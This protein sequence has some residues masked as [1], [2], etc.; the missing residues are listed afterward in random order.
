AGK[1]LG[2]EVVNVSPKGSSMAKGESLRD[3][4][5]T[6]DAMAP[7]VIVVRH[8]SPGAAAFL[9]REVAAG[10]VNAGD[11]AHQ[12]P[13][14]ALLDALT[15]KDRF[16]SLEGRRI[17]ICGDIRHSRVARSSA[18]LLHLLGARVRLGGPPTLLPRD[19]AGWGA[20][21]ATADMDEAI[22]GC[23][24][25]M[26]LRVQLERARGAVVPPIAE[27]RQ[28]YGLDHA[29]LARLAPD[30]LVMHP[31]PANRGVEIAADLADDPA[32]SLIRDQVE[33]GVAARMAVLERLL[34]PAE[35]AA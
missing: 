4:A 24:V 17:A 32:R 27:Y 33:A 10:V 26:V 16:G 15:L 12:H 8:S 6:V 35:A 34:A 21:T 30:A 11:G 9:A 31:G 3:T 20:E 25:V 29:R 14:Q 2:A 5:A 13:T 23:D 22:A 1:R 7:D 18:Q 28:R 19:P